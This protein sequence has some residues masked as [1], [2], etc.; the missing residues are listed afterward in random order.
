M[1]PASDA[2]ARPERTSNFGSDIGSRVQDF[3]PSMACVAN[4]DMSSAGGVIT[5]LTANQAPMGTYNHQRRVHSGTNN[6]G[7]L[8]S[9]DQALRG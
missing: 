7:A 2:L 5:G 1:V 8:S 3:S 9:L 6:S 4:D